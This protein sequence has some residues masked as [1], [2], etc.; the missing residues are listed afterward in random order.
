MTTVK[1]AP[2]FCSKCN[3]PTMPINAFQVN[4]N[5]GIYSN[6]KGHSFEKNLDVC[7]MLQKLK[8]QKLEEGDL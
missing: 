6:G 4:A 1:I 2:P 3:Q 7:L 8:K 5:G